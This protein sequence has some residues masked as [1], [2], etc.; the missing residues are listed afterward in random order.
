MS[1]LDGPLGLAMVGLG[2]GSI[3]GLLAFAAVCEL[4][5]RVRRGKQ[6]P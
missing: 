4:I 6:R 2:V 1:P 5:G 3:L